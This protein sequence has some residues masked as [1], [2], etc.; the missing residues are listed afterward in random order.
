MN[1]NTPHPVRRGYGVRRS[2]GA[3]IWMTDQAATTRPRNSSGRTW[4]HRV[5]S[6]DQPRTHPHHRRGARL[7]PE[8][9]HRLNRSQWAGGSSEQDPQ[10]HAGRAGH[11]NTSGPPPRSPTLG[12]IY[13]GGVDR[14]E[15]LG[16]LTERPPTWPRGGFRTTSTSHK[17]DI[18]W[19]GGRLPTS[20]IGG[21]A[22]DQ[23]LV[24]LRRRDE[25]DPVEGKG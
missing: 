21:G 8:D 19:S 1:P 22:M 17:Y 24:P 9:D 23:D 18:A 20:F 14:D 3:G 10:A 25:D 11:R 15:L 4:R 5:Y 2:I 16:C 7:T 13:V 6:G 12:V